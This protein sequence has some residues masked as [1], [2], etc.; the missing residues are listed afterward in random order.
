MSRQI[1]AAADFVSQNKADV[2]GAQAQMFGIAELIRL[3]RRL[4]RSAA[5]KILRGLA[6]TMRETHQAGEAILLALNARNRDGRLDL[7]QIGKFQASMSKRV[8][9]PGS[10][11]LLGLLARKGFIPSADVSEETAIAQMSAGLKGSGA[12]P[13]EK[14]GPS[15]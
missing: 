9:K 15:K 6:L 2:L 11:K 1:S 14:K 13:N 7:I 3:T 12:Q 5:N 4:D 8:V 10:R